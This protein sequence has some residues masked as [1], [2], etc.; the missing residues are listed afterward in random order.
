MGHIFMGYR[1]PDGAVGT[2]NYL[3]VIPSVFCA[4]TTAQ[5]IAAQIPGAVA[6][7][8]Q[9]HQCTSRADPTLM[10]LGRHLLAAKER[11]IQEMKRFL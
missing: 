9:L 4:N 5:K 8:R 3:T 10:E 11:N 6:L 2:R 1:R 7:T